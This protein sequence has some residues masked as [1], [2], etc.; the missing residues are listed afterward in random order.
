MTPNTQPNLPPANPK[1]LL[2]P[3]GAL[4]KPCA[5]VVFPDPELRSQLDGMK[6][7][8]LA[9]KGLGLAANQIGINKRMLVAKAPDGIRAFVNPTIV[10]FTGEWKMMDE[11]CLSLPG[12]VVPHKRN[13]GL[14]IE[15]ND[16]ATGA[17]VV[18]T[19]GGQLAHIL[20][21]EIDHLDGKMMI[22]HLPGGQR[23]KIRAYMRTVRR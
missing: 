6:A 19:V 22:D 2:W 16:A 23:D 14:L 13:T 5:S 8:M 15:F 4:K 21:H 7:A 3:H 11:G 18:D 1:I 20:Q 9:E 12:I 17:T 10:K